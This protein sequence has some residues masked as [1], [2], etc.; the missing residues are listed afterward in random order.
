MSQAA[1]IEIDNKLT[2]PQLEKHLWGAADIL[3]GRIDSSDYKHYIFGLLFFK[4]LSDVWQEEYDARM[5]K[6]NDAELAAL[7][8]QLNELEDKFSE[9]PAFV[10]LL[11]SERKS[12]NL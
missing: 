2:L 10:A 3:R 7:R 4:R 11:K 1:K 8:N 5:A 6:Y 12:S 9:D